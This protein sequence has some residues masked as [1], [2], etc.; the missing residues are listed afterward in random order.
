M[1]PSKCPSRRSERTNIT[2]VKEGPV[3]WYQ[4]SV[5]KDAGS[6]E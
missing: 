2:P 3:R 1:R 6:I 4:D 5:S